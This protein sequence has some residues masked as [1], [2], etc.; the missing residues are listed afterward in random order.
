LSNMSHVRC[1]MCGKD[2]AF[3]SFNPEDLDPD[4]YVRQT[5]GLGYGGGFS[6]GPDESV[7]GDD[8]FTPKVMDRCVELLKL[9]IE[10]GSVTSREL[11]V[12]LK[13]GV[14][15]QGTDKVAPYEDVL[16]IYNKQIEALKKEV[17]SLKYQV[18]TA[19]SGVSILE[20][21]ELKTRYNKLVNHARVKREI[22]EILSYLHD[23]LDS[24]IVLGEDD[25]ELEVYEYAPAIF[26]YLC[27]KLYTLN[28]MERDT[29]ENRINT[30]CTDL[31]FIFR[32]FKDKPT[33]RS[34]AD[35]MIEKPDRFYNALHNPPISDYCKDQGDNNQ[36]NNWGTPST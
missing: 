19:R 26:G 11:A 34:I 10:K 14:P 36:D 12:K 3:S 9:G 27:K 1:P 4:I 17:T 30:E 35:L 15:F 25:W 21:E 8:Y 28:R 24:E 6:Y 7:L 33:I 20:Y 13:L 16:D 22:D 31:K 5:S 18:S 29:L 23:V 32:F 2:S